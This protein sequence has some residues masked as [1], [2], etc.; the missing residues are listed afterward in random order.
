[1]GAARG[2]GTTAMQP[3]AIGIKATLDV[4]SIDNNL[5]LTGQ[6][7][8]QLPSFRL[9][10]KKLEIAVVDTMIQKPVGQLV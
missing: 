6:L 5:I 7:N 9:H 2:A 3:I 1:M 10:P 8:G 4:F